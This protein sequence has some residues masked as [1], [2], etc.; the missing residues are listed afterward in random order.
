M[1]PSVCAPLHRYLARERAHTDGLIGI[2]QPDETGLDASPAYDRPLGWR[3][4]PSPGF[5]ALQS[6]NRLRGYNYRRVVADGGFH[7]IDALVNT[8]WILGW[9]G[10][11]RLG[12]AGAAER[13]HALTRALTHR[14][15]D[16]NVGFFFTEGPNREPLRVR[17]WAGLAPLAIESLP[18][19]I[20]HRLITQ[21]LL[22]E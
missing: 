3:S 17:T 7:A 10:L 5:L 8:A 21:H 12:T 13:A 2:L 1:S 6:F 19:E 22:D 9:E 20:G 4:H 15:Y 16:A 14:L 11:A 18:P